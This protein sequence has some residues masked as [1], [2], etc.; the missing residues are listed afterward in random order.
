V[1]GDAKRFPLHGPGLENWDSAV[2][3]SFQLPWE[4][5]KLEF[6]GEFYN[7]LNHTNWRQPSSAVGKK[8]YGVIT[9][10][11]DPRIMQFTA[12]IVF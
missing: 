6:R 8:N 1:L 7:T 10:A 2:T 12:K 3:R 11:N 9:K 4:R 5:T